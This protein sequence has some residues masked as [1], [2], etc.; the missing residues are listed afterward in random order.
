MWG[1]F[2][3]WVNE[4]I[5]EP[6]KGSWFDSP[7]WVTAILIHGRGDFGTFYQLTQVGHRNN[8][9]LSVKTLSIVKF[10]ETRARLVKN[11]QN[12]RY[13]HR[14]QRD[15]LVWIVI[16][17]T[18]VYDNEKCTERRRIWSLGQR[19]TELRARQHYLWTRFIVFW[20]RDVV[21]CMHQAR[22]LQVN[23]L[24]LHCAKCGF[25]QCG[26]HR[27]RRNRCQLWTSSRS[28]STV[29]GITI[30]NTAMASVISTC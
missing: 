12:Y 22:R 8:T 5:I 27:M 7:W 9:V 4:R 20:K 13:E 15:V 21:K 6:T 17:Q 2:F 18:N 16:L 14:Q 26:S 19:V 23:F 25:P 1:Y 30:E 28:Y 24:M 3:I 29:L 10:T 11:W